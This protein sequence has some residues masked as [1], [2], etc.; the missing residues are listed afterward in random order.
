MPAGPA[1]LPLGLPSINYQEQAQSAQPVSIGGAPVGGGPLPTSS[2]P[3]PEAGRLADRA[4]WTRPNAPQRWEGH[5]HPHAR[6]TR[7]AL[8]RTGYLDAKRCRNL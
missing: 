4:G 5:G 8:R 1:P 2:G 6:G 3:D 7:L